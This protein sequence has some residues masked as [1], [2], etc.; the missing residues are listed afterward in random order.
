MTKFTKQVKALKTATYLTKVKYAIYSQGGLKTLP[1][2]SERLSE[3]N[4]QL[5]LVVINND[6]AALNGLEMMK[7]LSLGSKSDVFTKDWWVHLSGKTLEEL[8]ASEVEMDTDMFV[9]IP[10]RVRYTEALGASLFPTIEL[11]KD[12]ARQS[13]L[14]KPTP[15][16]AVEKNALKKK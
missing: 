4:I 13:P 15:I 1:D 2:G 11:L 6:N 10:C 16:P 9:G 8:L 7:I 12:D 3:D 14:I 5:T